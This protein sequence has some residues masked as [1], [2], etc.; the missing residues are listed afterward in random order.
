MGIVELIR[1]SLQ[2]ATFFV[3]YPYPI[4]RPFDNYYQLTWIHFIEPFLFLE[5]DG[6]ILL[7]LCKPEFHGNK[8]Y[9]ESVLRSGP[10]RSFHLFVS[11]QIEFE[12]AF[13]DDAS[14]Q[15]P[16]IPREPSPE[17]LEA[18]VSALDWFNLCLRRQFVIELEERVSRSD[19]RCR[20]EYPLLLHYGLEYVV[21]LF[22]GYLCLWRGSQTTITPTADSLVV[23]GFDHCVL[24]QLRD[25]RFVPQTATSGVLRFL[26]V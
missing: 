1:Q 24:A 9:A 21:I 13:V 2:D 17:G 6:T 19:Y 5:L 7:I 3:H 12:R 23:S 16:R 25:C 20:V 14:A 18:G 8:L 10:N 22:D 15:P 4:E 26:C 11:A